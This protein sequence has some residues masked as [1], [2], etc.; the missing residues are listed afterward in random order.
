MS[1][2]TLLEKNEK[3]VTDVEVGPLGVTLVMATLQ[4]V[5]QKNLYVKRMFVF[6]DMS[7]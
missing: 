7:I 5:T 2:A 6:N 4:K 3:N 1:E